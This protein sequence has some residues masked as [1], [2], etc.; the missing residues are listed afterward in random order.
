MIG[1][2][3]GRDDLKGG[4]EIIREQMPSLHIFVTTVGMQLYTLV[5]CHNFLKDKFCFVKVFL[6][7]NGKRPRYITE[8]FV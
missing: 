8:I 6:K 4:V 3:T 1:M 5:K 7:T 2:T